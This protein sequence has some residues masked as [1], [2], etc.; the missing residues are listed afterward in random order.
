MGDTELE[1]MTPFG[2]DAFASKRGKKKTVGPIENKA[3][4]TIVLI[5]LVIRT[6]R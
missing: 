5:N 4:T 6:S 1:V 2:L 3:N